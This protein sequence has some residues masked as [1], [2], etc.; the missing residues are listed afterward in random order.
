VARQLRQCR[1]GLGHLHQG[2]QTF[3]HARATAGGKT[4]EGGTRHDRGL[5]TKNETLADHRAHRATHELELEGRRDH[6]NMLDVAAHHHQRIGFAGGRLRLLEALGVFLA[7]LE[8][9][10]I[11][12]GDPR[13]DL[14][15]PFGIEQHVEATPGADAVV[16]TALGAD[17]EIALQIRAVQHLV[18]GRALRPQA[19]RHR[20]AR[21]HPALDL[22]RQDFLKPAHK[23]YP[24]FIPL[25]LEGRGRGEGETHP[26]RT[27]FTCSPRRRRG[28][29][30]RPDA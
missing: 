4:D 29:T 3:L 15:A 12:R 13:A 25:S 19:F 21:L 7:V 8:L 5:D 26:R 17:F 20:L 6:R 22:R 2:K 27:F 18:A 1:R 28:A 10:R 16:M 9:E 30:R 11:E 23:K 24:S 14:V